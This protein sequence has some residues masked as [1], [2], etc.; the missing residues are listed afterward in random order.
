MDTLA[1]DNTKVYGISYDPQSSL[2]EFTGQFDL[3]FDLLSDIDSEVIKKFGILNTLITDDDTETHPQSKR[4]FYGLPFPGVY[5]TDEDGVV[6]EKFF[7]RHY[8][9]RASAGSIMNSALGEVLMP[10]E[11]PRESM[12]N[13]Q[14]KITAF[15]VDESLKF[16]YRSMINVRLELADGLHIYGGDLPKGFFSTTA[17][18]D[19][20]KG[21]R[22]GDAMYP[23]TMPMRFDALD[24]TLNVYDGIVDI[25]IPVSLTAEVMNWISRNK[26]KFMEI[27]V[28]VN[29][30]AC[31]GTVCY[32]PKTE[33]LTVRV[34]VSQLIMPGM[35]R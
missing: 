11:S 2:K 23:E 18:I 32:T 33:S 8:A 19:D 16:E 25:K 26:P 6:T 12:R 24:A 13:D 7:F 1:K 27:P 28:N 4:G 35:R 9:A 21:L 15:L 10:K 14:I 20:T 29:Y 5:V 22:I 30:Q 31:S 3:G 17:S 34:P